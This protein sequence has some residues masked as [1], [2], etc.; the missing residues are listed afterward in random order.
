MG[1]ESEWVLVVEFIW[2]MGVTKGLEEH[3]SG[4]RTGMRGK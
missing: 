3:W 2:K 4:G 1:S